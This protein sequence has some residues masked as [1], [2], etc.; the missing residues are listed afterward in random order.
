MTHPTLFD[1]AP[2]MQLKSCS[3]CSQLLPITE[4]RARN[5]AYKLY[6]RCRA[7]ERA[8]QLRRYHAD[9]E[10]ARARGRRNQAAR[11]TSEVI[12]PA[13]R[14]AAK[15]RRKDGI[16]LTTNRRRI[17]RLK[18]QCPFEWYAQ[19]YRSYYRVPLTAADLQSLW[20]LQRGCCGLTG[21]EMT[22]VSDAELDHI[23]PTSRNGGFGIA[24]L[25]WTCRSA[26]RAKHNLT[27]E[28]FIALCSEVAEF[29]ARAALA[30][31]RGE[32]AAA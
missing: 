30:H 10:V 25:R 12:A 18:A 32:R 13:L 22:L 17:A 1:A 5:G 29:I 8:E 6:A 19:K 27:D 26:N 4:F 14:R 11:C 21:R 31:I 9:I 15:K 2:A 16:D 7:C 20:E 24:N 3:R 23:V 28:E